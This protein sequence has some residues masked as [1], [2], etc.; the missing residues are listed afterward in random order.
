MNQA[1]YRIVVGA[2]WGDEGKGRMVDYFAQSADLV[3]RYQGGNNAGHTVINEHGTFKLH[4]IPSGVFNPNAINL[5]GPGMVVDLAGFKMEVE[6]LI[7]QGIQPNVKV[8]DRAT[9]VLPIHKLEDN[10]EEARLGKQAYG[11]TRNGIAYAYADRYAK[12]AIQVGWLKDA[13]ILKR[14]LKQWYD[15]KI[16]MLKGLYGEADALPFDELY[17]QLTELAEFV[18]P[19]ITDTLAVSRN[20]KPNAQVV[21]EAQLGSL[22]D[23]HFGNYPYTT[24]SS[25]LSGAAEIGS[26]LFM[27]QQPTVTAVV[28]AFSSSVGN[29][30]FP[31]AMTE[32]DNFRDHSEE[33]GA[34]T[35]RPRDVGHFDAFATRYGIALQKADEVALT[36]LDCLSGMD[37]LKLCTAYR[38]DGEVLT[39]Y[40]LVDELFSAEPVYETMPGWQEDITA[41]RAFYDLP[42]AAQDY[43]LRIE[44]LTQCR[45]NYISVGPSREQIILR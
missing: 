23:L 15:W 39:D 4:L 38:C 31:T 10:L 43:V 26:G 16:P 7:E 36:K 29:G 41:I 27:K 11:S 22:R 25:V 28:K 40:P 9:L 21:L 30:P 14:Q 44:Q 2:N 12:K 24:S 42:K 17:H 5:L 45:I 13:V 1:H 19:Y 35:G 34:S 37:T 6:Q 3:G 20:L 8:S 33:F 32:M 18:K